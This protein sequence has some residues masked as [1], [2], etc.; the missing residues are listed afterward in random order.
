MRAR[1]SSGFYFIFLFKQ[2]YIPC[3]RGAYIIDAQ[4]IGK[5]EREKKKFP[6][7]RMKKKKER[8]VK[9]TPDSEFMRA[10]EKEL[11]TKMQH[12]LFFFFLFNDHYFFFLTD[13]SI[14]LSAVQLF[15]FYFFFFPSFLLT[16]PAFLK[17]PGGVSCFYDGSVFLLIFFC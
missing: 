9:G 4:S 6:F 14:C 15:L 3:D 1:Q 13:R 7:L 8:N 10:H 17:P 2:I 5:R 12:E 11:N 16:L